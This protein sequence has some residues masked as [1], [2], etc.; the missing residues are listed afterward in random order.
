MK[1]IVIVGT[2]GSGK[3]TLAGRLS[4]RLGYKHI[5]LDALFWEPNWTEAP[6]DVFR[7]RVED[8]IAGEVWIVDGNYTGKARD[9]IWRRA[10]TFIW[11]DYSL[12]TVMRRLALRTFR[13]G[14]TRERLWGK[15]RESL[16]EQLFTRRSLFLWALQ[17]HGKHRA[18][19]PELFKCEVRSNQMIVHLR[20]PREA[21]AWLSH[22]EPRSH[23]LGM[24]S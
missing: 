24:Q 8:A 15:N 3:S 14:A 12:V 5:E 2:T 22:I 10:D 11:L 6:R 7:G 23:L 13:R 18:Q 20:S 21:E 4:R 17:T 16:S 1:R 19:F 9:I